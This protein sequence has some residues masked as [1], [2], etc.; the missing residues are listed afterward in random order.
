MF[1]WASSETRS[2]HVLCSPQAVAAGPIAAAVPLATEAVAGAEAP[3]R[4]DD[5]DMA[6]AGGGIDQ[7]EWEVADDDADDVASRHSGDEED[8][9]GSATPIARAKAVVAFQVCIV[10]LRKSCDP[11]ARPG[12]VDVTIPSPAEPTGVRFCPHR[13]W[14]AMR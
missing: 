13:S 1:V 11:V 3:A 7:D 2:T 10:C 6:S 9:L 14:K 8:E 12:V 5:E 4:D